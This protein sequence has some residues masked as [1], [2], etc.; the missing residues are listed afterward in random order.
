MSTPWSNRVFLIAEAGVNH[1]GDP[2]LALEMLE[3]AAAAGADAVKFQ[4]F[5]A[6]AL[7]TST[8][9]MADYQMRNLRTAGSQIDM[10]KRLELSHDAHRI[11]RR[12]AQ[13]LGILFFS[14]AFDRP[15]M[16]FLAELDQPLWKIPSGEITN[17]PYL[18]A[19]ARFDRPVV[20]STGMATVS[21][22]DD[23]VTTLIE[24]GLDRDRLC[25]LHCN[26]EYP[27]PWEDV[28]LRAM[29]NIGALFGCTFGYSD[30]TPGIEIS[31]AAV[32]MGAR[33]LEK[34]FT[35]NQDLPGPDHKASLSPSQLI[36][37]VA[38]TRHVELALGDGVKRPTPSE[39]KN[40][41]IA[42]KV[43]VAR[44]GI[45]KG[46]IFSADN[47]TAKRAGPGLSPMMWPQ[48]LGRAATRD[49]NADEV[50]EL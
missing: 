32:A 42:R 4:T 18:A 43:V 15:S 47:L 2:S 23:A 13:E 45:A 14:T 37:W 36:D 22:I 34:H 31:I 10:L 46:E 44:C 20:L 21:E 49:F 27:T 29:P 1:N 7:V 26:T 8:T 30:H 12:R 3:L 50:I 19:I 17:Y 28:N 33:V 9:R 38:S 48:L 24:H 16:D 41:D 39:V 35:L 40:R 25:I 5:Q 6:E 11:L